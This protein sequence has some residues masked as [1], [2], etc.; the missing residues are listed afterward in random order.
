MSA[1]VRAAGWRPTSAVQ[2]RNAWAWVNRSWRTGR[3]WGAAGGGGA[4]A[5]RGEL[6]PVPE[7]AQ[8]PQVGMAVQGVE[9][10]GEPGLV[11]AQ[12][13]VGGGQ[14]AAVDEQFTQVDRRRVAGP[15]VECL[16]GQRQRA[17]GQGVSRSR[18][19]G[20]ASQSSVAAGLA[21]AARAA[22]SGF[23]GGLTE[24]VPSSSSRPAVQATAHGPHSR[25]SHRRP[26]DGHA[27]LGAA[28]QAGKVAGDA[29]AVPA[30]R[31]RRRAGRAAAGP[32]CRSRGRSRRWPA[33]RVRHREHRCPSGNE[34]EG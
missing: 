14:G 2:V 3:R 7:L 1:W 15:G 9:A 34:A 8:Q 23:S 11:V 33:P 6:V 17:G 27:G 25:V 31:D 12:L 22:A 18:M 26:S 24:P 13:P 20:F 21:V 16:V 32:R 4:G 5:H 28:A 29:G 19:C 10:A 30:D